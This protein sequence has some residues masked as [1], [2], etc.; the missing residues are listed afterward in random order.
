VRP[1]SDVIAEIKT[2]EGDDI[3]FVDDNLIGKT[4][5]TNE[6][7]SRL[8]PLKKKWIG[9]AAVTVANQQSVL[10][11]LQKGGCEGL[12]I[13]LETSSNANLKEVGKNQNINIDYVEAVKK[14]HDHGIA[15]L[16][17]FIVG[18][19][20]DDKSCF[21]SLLEFV[22]KSKVDV[23][24]VAVLTPY[25]GT[26]LYERLKSQNRLI[27][28]QWWLKYDASDVVFRPKRMNRV[29]L[30]E[31]RVWVLK[32]LHKLGPLLKRWLG[33]LG[34]RSIYGDYISLKA[35]LGYRKNAN[36]M[37]LDSGRLRNS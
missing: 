33:G 11:A 18:F 27:D 14:L 4:A 23:V 20:S 15:I 24:D 29:E 31:G 12:F 1:I 26:I 3:L 22:A 36:A 9:Q 6:L 2:L 5:Y 34:G 8:A 16:G 37:P 30:Y 10:K 28:N 19:D 25:P 7:L 35:N 21:E 13:G 17:S 32:E